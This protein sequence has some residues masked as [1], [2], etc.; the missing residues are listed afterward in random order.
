MLMEIHD[1][2]LI[3]PQVEKLDRAIAAGCDELVL[4]DL[5]P[6]EVVQ[7]IIRVE[8]CAENCQPI[9]VS[10]YQAPNA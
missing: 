5:G 4:V 6:S 8:A 2:K 1:G 7:G 10:P 9:S 3:N